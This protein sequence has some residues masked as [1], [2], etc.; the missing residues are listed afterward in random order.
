MMHPACEANGHHYQLASNPY[1]KVTGVPR[2]RFLP[3]LGVKRD[4][5]TRYVKLFCTQCGDAKEILQVD[6][7][8]G[9]EQIEQTLGGNNGKSNS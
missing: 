8:F 1:R 4:K 9:L 2:V 5:K 3:F 7:R 6:I